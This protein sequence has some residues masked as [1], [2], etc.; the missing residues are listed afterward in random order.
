MKAPILCLILPCYNEEDIL[1][2]SNAQLKELLATLIMD[3]VVNPDSFIVFVDDGSRDS[4]WPIIEAL[5]LQTPFIKGVKLAKNFGHQNALLAGLT[6]FQ[7]HADCF[8]TIDAD[9]QDDIRTIPEMV[10]KFSSGYDIVYGVRKKRDNDSFFKKYTALLFYELMKKMGVEL[11][12]NHADFRLSSKRVLEELLKFNEVNLFLRGIYPLIGFKSTSVYYDR[13]ERKV[14]ET[15]F[16]FRK[17][18]S[19]AMKGI[20]AFS[21]KP[22]R[23]MTIVGFL[24]FIT[25]LGAS[26]YAFYSYLFQH[27]IKGWMS[28]V[29]PMYLLGGIQ[30]LFIGVL[31]EYLAKIYIEVK[32]RPRFVIETELK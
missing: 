9:L 6:S 5:H 24:I 10:E 26:V 14:G 20:T 12:Y 7:Q 30:L 11:I 16:P 19:F 4:T 31:G 13:L 32:K 8:I 29:L 3:K 2:Y 27:S 15:K 28:I 25:S 17:M 22:L 23:I 1:S 21:I 18:V